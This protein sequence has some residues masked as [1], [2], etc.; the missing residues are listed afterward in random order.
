MREFNYIEAWFSYPY[1]EIR[2]IKR[3]EVNDMDKIL[4]IMDIVKN[5]T[6]D[7]NLNIPM[8]DKV[9]EIL[10]SM[11]IG[12]LG[13]YAYVV[14]VYGHWQPSGTK[15]EFDNSKGQTWKFTNVVTQYL[16]GKL[17]YDVDKVQI[18]DGLIRMT[19]I[20][21]N[22]WDWD[23]IGY[24]NQYNIDR[25]DLA[26]NNIDKDHELFKRCV[27]NSKIVVDFAPPQT[28]SVTL[29]YLEYMA[30]KAFS[31]SKIYYLDSEMAGNVYDKIYK[32]MEDCDT[33]NVLECNKRK[34]ELIK[35]EVLKSKDSEVYSIE[36]FLDAFNNGEV[37]TS[38]LV[39][40]VR[41]D[42]I[43]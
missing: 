40:L 10:D 38:G 28:Y 1:R 20:A 17:K 37:L 34:K 24:A 5:E 35:R 6:Q 29:E 12:K 41:T 33:D 15:L 8:S 2:N 30:E 36:E 32:F 18:V 43:F 13:Y 16:R 27:A 39:S 23:D 31:G 14:Y 9:I 11:D 19:F 26:Y 4:Q 25:I 7:K 3:H 21:P 42:K 22:H